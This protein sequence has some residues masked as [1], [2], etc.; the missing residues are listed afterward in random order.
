M[1]RAYGGENG[2]ALVI[3]PLIDH[4]RQT[5]QGITISPVAYFDADQFSA[6]FQRVVDG[7]MANRD[8]IA[9]FP[10]EHVLTTMFAVF[11]VAI[12]CTKHP[13]FAEEREWRL[14]FHPTL[15]SSP[16][17][18]HSFESVRGVPQEVYKIKLENDPDNDIVR[19]D[20]PTLIDRIIIGP[21]TQP[22]TLRQTFVKVLAEAGVPDADSRV[23]ASLVPLRHF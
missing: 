10:R 13:G 14:F 17:V 18:E 1:W 11:K 21:T 15:A 5:P 20:I 19:A 2:I 3:K 8:L 4:L 22:L 7:M 6:E 12:L 9:S 16:L 23:W